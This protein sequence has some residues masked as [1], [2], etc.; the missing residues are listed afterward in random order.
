MKGIDSLPAPRLEVR[1]LRMVLALAAAGTTAQ[2]A[3]VLHLTQPAVSR[4]LSA[5]EARLGAKLFER[6]PRGLVPTEVGRRLIEEAGR[7]LI[8]LTELEQR[9]AEPP[10]SP[11]KLRIVCECYTAYHWVPTVL[12]S[13]RDSL[14]DLELQLAIE[15][16]AEPVAALVEGEIDVA[17]LTTATLPAAAR[18]MLAERKLFSDEVVFVMAK[19]HRLATQRVIT[20]ADLLR[21]RV[22][23][24][25]APR[26]EQRWFM[27]RVFGRERPRLDLLQLPLTE[28]IVD[29]ARAGMGVAVLS[30]WIASPHFRH[31]ELVAKRLAS[32]PL[33]RP[34][35]L[36]Y[37]RDLGDA[38]RRLQTALET[39]VP[40]A[41]L[42]G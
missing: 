23:V 9:A 29:V 22:L 30:E 24:S 14:S 38:A 33:L 25:N 2:A 27:T 36:A 12:Q 39:S 32:G 7:F 18:G 37:R 17:L 13:L 5:A 19:T 42:A 21:E 41:R 4:A 10:R 6:T 26:S 40:Q 3:H 35:R 34:W 20:P 31:G 1:D 15:S 28:A 8:A 11:Q 16:T